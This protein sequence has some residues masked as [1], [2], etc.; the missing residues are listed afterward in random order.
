MATAR[1]GEIV[2]REQTGEQQLVALVQKMG[3]EIARALPKTVTPDRMARIVLTALRTVP[4]L[5]E[6]T[7]ASFIGC[8][9]SAAQLGLEPNTPLGEVYLIPRKSN[10]NGGRMEC[11][12][13]LGYQG[14]MT[15]ARRSGLVGAIW[16]DVVRAGD[17]YQVKLGL[18]PDLVHEP[19]GDD[20]REQQPVV[21]AY[22]CAR[23][24]GDEMPVF[25]AMSRAQIEAIRRRSGAR[26]DGPW[27]TDYAEMAKKVAIARL[28]KVL[29]KSAEMARSEA[30][31]TA[32]ELGRDQSQAWDPGVSKA[33]AQ[34]GLAP[35]LPPAEDSGPRAAE[36]PHDADGVVR[37]PGED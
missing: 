19:S 26:D 4:K 35:E 11:T 30:L 34:A 13:I 1:N 27:T 31:D 16:A 32:D 37:E 7:P 29:P 23:V 12:M 22:A 17:H 9:M 8:V 18:H 36:V 2:K 15:L 33:L 20:D 3:P 10:R 14:K 24:K 5:A 6:C 21:A 28:Y 25:I